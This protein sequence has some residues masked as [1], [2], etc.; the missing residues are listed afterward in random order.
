[1]PL[2][3]KSPVTVKLSFIVVSEVVCPIDIGTPDVAVPIV[4]PLDV[5]ELS[6]FKVDVLS[7]EIFEPSTT[8]VPS[9]SVLS[10][11]VVPSTSKSPLK[12]A[13]LLSVKLVPVIAAALAPPITA[14][15]IVPPLISAVSATSESMFAVP[16]INKSCHSLD[17]LPKS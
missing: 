8:N 5:L 13:L 4:I 7:S 17:E 3:V 1:M 14:P 15:S 12:S 2:T 11:L 10:K 6:I 16:S 9:I